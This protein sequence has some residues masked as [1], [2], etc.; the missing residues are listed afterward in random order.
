MSSF[1]EILKKSIIRGLSVP[2]LSLFIINLGNFIPALLGMVFMPFFLVEMGD[3]YST[4]SFGLALLSVA[5]IFEG[6]VTRV[7][8]LRIQR[9]IS[10]GIHRAEQLCYELN[11]GYFYINCITVALIPIGFLVTLFLP[12]LN[13]LS[14]LSFVLYF[15]VLSMT[16]LL[17]G[18][19]EVLGDYRNHATA[20]IIYA[21]LL[22]LF[23]LYLVILDLVSFEFIVNTGIVAKLVELL[24]LIVVS[25]AKLRV[26]FL[27]YRKFR[28]TMP[29]ILS[30]LIA[31]SAGSGF[32]IVDKLVV[33]TA[34]EAV[35]ASIYMGWQDIVLKYA[36]FLSSFSTLFLKKANEKNTKLNLMAAMLLLHGLIVCGFVIGFWSLNL[37]FGVLKK[38]GLILFL[39]FA[40]G[41][42]F[43]ALSAMELISLQSKNMYRTIMTVQLLELIIFTIVLWLAIDAWNEYALAVVTS[44]RM[45]I[46]FAILR[47]LSKKL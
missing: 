39:I 27:P 35:N 45:V 31:N 29:K 37:S 1:R 13:S 12:S 43:N 14:M 41:I 47:Y 6:G 10:K 42:I 18:Y 22:N 8:S 40:T 26:R 7:T 24:F 36:I 32:F 4:L 34:L 20:K 2:L 16:S 19:L 15:Y 9:L 46:D 44:G 5:Y 25:K 30:N 38:E 33:L 17:R 11:C 21:L 28:A 23:I 3:K